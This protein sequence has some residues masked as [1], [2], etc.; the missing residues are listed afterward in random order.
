MDYALTSFLY[1]I[2]NIISNQLA[3]YIVLWVSSAVMVT[4]YG[5]GM[6]IANY[7]KEFFNTTQGVLF[8]IFSQRDGS[9]K[10]KDI[11][12]WM[13]AG[14][15]VSAIVAATGGAMV[16]LYG[17]Q[18]LERWL[19]P[20]FHLSYSYCVILITP[21]I[22]S[23]SVFPCKEILKATG[24]HWQATIIDG[25]G[26]VTNFSI[27]I[28]FGYK[29][30]AIGVAI[31]AAVSCVLFE[32]IVKPYYACRSIHVSPYKYWGVV[33][34]NVLGVGISIIPFWYF[35][36]RWVEAKYSSLLLLL[37]IHLIITLLFSYF[38]LLHNNEKDFISSYFKKV[39]RIIKIR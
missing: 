6:T 10:V 32:C 18:F 24:K 1:T 7:F 12:K 30:G 37:F 2:N 21:L 25:I 8:P 34:G 33:W 9:G 36:R 38:I 11:E 3:P 28:L 14:S 13:F 22:F 4:Y 15:R 35:L 29:L 23:Y 27:G 31:G 17:R 20:S 16:V 5:I 19:G 26:S 39:F